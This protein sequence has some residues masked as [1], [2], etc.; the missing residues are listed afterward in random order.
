MSGSSQS[1]SRPEPC[2]PPTLSDAPPA[3]HRNVAGP[4]KA[5]GWAFLGIRDSNA[6]R[7]DVARVSPLLWIGSGL[8]AVVVFVF[9][10]IAFVRWLVL[11]AVS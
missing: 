8:A 3:A 2:E 11:P 6:H 4:L 5:I 9:A 10:L 1:A 7:Q